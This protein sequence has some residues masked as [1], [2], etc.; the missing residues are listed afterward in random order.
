MPEGL[1]WPIGHHHAAGIS[2]ALGQLG[3]HEYSPAWIRA[4]FAI[5]VLF[6]RNGQRRPAA[7]WGLMCWFAAAVASIGENR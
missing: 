5:F 6:S 1:C 3:R 2:L 7:I 4:G